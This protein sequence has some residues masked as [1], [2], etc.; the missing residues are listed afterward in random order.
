M[1]LNAPA[2]PDFLVVLPVYSNTRSRCP[3]AGLALKLVH[4]VDGNLVVAG[5]SAGDSGVYATGDFAR[6]SSHP[7]FGVTYVSKSRT[8]M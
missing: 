7:S 2:A 3:L 1:A 8:T 5:H 4:R 6:P